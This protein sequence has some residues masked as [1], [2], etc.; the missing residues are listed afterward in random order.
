MHPQFAFE[1]P[2]PRLEL[3]HAVANDALDLPVFP[4]LP[5]GKLGN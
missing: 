3:V 1:I 5:V 2:N 4:A